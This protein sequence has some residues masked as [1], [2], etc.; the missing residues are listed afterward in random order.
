MRIFTVKKIHNGLLHLRIM[1]DIC[2]FILGWKSQWSRW[3]NHRHLPPGWQH[4]TDTAV[5][6]PVP[7]G[8]RD[9]NACAV[10]VLHVHEVCAGTVQRRRQRQCQSWGK[11]MNFYVS[12]ASVHFLIILKGKYGLLGCYPTEIDFLIASAD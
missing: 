6:D 8:A 12:M 2:N 5:P 1:F 11:N 9:Y 7:A 3:G 10:H 4:L